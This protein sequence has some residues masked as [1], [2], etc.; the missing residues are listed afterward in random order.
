MSGQ[1]VVIRDE[2]LPT[3]LFNAA[4][5]FAKK[6]YVL[7]GSWVLGILVCLFATGFAPD[8]QSLQQYQVGVNI[9]AYGHVMQLIVSSTFTFENA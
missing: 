8:S 5:Q 6:H 4:G 7:S 9:I 2:E 1:S 3:L